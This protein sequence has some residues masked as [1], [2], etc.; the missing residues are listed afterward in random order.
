MSSG[1]IGGLFSPN[2]VGCVSSLAK[3]PLRLHKSAAAAMAHRP[4]FRAERSEAERGASAA[5]SS[6][7]HARRLARSRG[8]HEPNR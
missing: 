1:S 4:R 6:V 3:A 2:G 8:V 5:E 7:M